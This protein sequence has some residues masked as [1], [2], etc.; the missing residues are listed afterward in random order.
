MFF[1]V[2]DVQ[3]PALE[4][5]DGENPYNLPQRAR[6]EMQGSCQLMRN[7]NE[8]WCVCVR[9][10]DYFVFLVQLKLIIEIE[11]SYMNTNHPDFIGFDR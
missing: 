7:K 11:L 9:L 6:T 3:V 5:R 1:F 8:L 4:G 2:T 10:S